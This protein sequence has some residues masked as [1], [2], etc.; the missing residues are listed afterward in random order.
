MKP[1]VL[2][3]YN[4]FNELYHEIL[5]DFE[6]IMPAPGV[7]SFKYN[8]VVEMIKDCDALLSMWNFPVDKQLLD[9][10]EKLKIVAKM[11]FVIKSIIS[12][13]SKFNL[14]CTFICLTASVTLIFLNS[15]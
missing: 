11:K 4:V 8:E 7:K 2:I 12:F 5:K 14:F 1:K 6:V 3:T 15:F 13:L 10:A 9:A